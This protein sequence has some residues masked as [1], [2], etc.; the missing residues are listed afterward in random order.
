LNRFEEA[1]QPAEAAV[2]ADPNHAEAHEL[3]GTLFAGK[4]Q[5]A[6][7][8]REYRRAIELRPDFGQAHLDLARVLNAQG[9]RAGAVQHLREAAKDRDAGVAQQ[10]AQ[11]LRQIGAQ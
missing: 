4:R 10:A 1:Q 7:A 6:E 11:A 8:A 2:K 9:D 5:L 3:L